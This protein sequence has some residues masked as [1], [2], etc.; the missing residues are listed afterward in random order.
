MTTHTAGRVQRLLG[1]LLGLLM[2]WAA[3]SKL[4]N[5]TEFLGSLY[6]YQLPLPR[7]VMQTVAVVLPWLELLCGLLLVSGLW[8]ETAL[9]I[10]TTLLAVFVLATGQA[11]LRG[12]D[13]SCG[14]F[15]LKVFGLDSSPGLD[16][17]FESVAFAFFRNLVLLTVTALLFRKQL[18]TTSTVAQGKITT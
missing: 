13:I 2:L 9:A 3:V 4:A 10:V 14:C 6:G 17:F 8:M 11:W 18:A 16:R 12:L 1:G 7:L 15:S 5:P